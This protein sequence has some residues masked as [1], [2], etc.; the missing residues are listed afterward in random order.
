MA[1]P[2][3]PALSIHA[4]FDHFVAVPALRHGATEERGGGGSMTVNRIRIWDRLVESLS[5]RSRTQIEA[6]PTMDRID[7]A[8]E[9]AR[10][11]LQRRGL[12]PESGTFLNVFA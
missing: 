8:I 1:V 4:R 5:S 9:T 7:A 3:Q 12:L 10:S 6:P 11:L 2:I